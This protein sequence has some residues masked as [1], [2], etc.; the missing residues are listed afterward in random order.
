MSILFKKLKSLTTRSSSRDKK[1]EEPRLRS[2]NVYTFQRMIFSPKGLMLIF[3]TIAGFF[4]ISFYGLSFLKNHL[5]AGS[6]RAIVMQQNQQTAGPNGMPGMDPYGIDPKTGLPYDPEV[7]TQNHPEAASAK[8][9]V[10]FEVPKFFLKR[11]KKA[12][13]AE[14]NTDLPPSDP[15]NS[16][17][18]IVFEHL[19]PLPVVSPSQ[20]TEKQ[21]EPIKTSSQK[22]A[23]V[24]TAQ[25]SEKSTQKSDDSK[26]ISENNALKAENEVEDQKLAER[27]NLHHLIKSKKTREVSRMVSL[28]TELEDAV[29][30]ND[31][32][33]ADRILEELF[34]EKIP[35]QPYVLKLMAYKQ[36][37][38]NNYHKAKQ[39]LQTVLTQDK[40]DFEAG[41]NMAIIE[42]RQQEFSSAQK[43]LIKLREWYPSREIIENLLDQ[44]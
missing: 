4:M 37:K 34:K 23:S 16:G 12:I 20:T 11:S 26:A 29:A 6:N 7:F 43:R 15:V 18:K 31:T 8:P 28:S 10:K 41:I 40:T 39:Y 14:K 9:A 42:I 36:I 33:R 44:L 22:T 25:I 27:K 17:Q 30:K 21:E 24:K 1:E 38:K 3:A 35:S 32:E 19:P 2:Q 5:D 13:A